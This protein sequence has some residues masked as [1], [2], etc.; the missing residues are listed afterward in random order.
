MQNITTSKEE[1]KKGNRPVHSKKEYEEEAK[2][3][4]ERNKNKITAISKIEDDRPG[5]SDCSNYSTL[6][7]P[8]RAKDK[9]DLNKTTSM[10]NINK[11]RGKQE[12]EDKASLSEDAESITIK[13]MS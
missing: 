3:P 7:A 13:Q 5:D 8:R 4:I 6:I 11:R 2:S 1:C 10:Q 12:K 9:A